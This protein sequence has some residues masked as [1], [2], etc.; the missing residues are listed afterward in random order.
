MKFD[1]RYLIALNCS[2]ALHE[3]SNIDDDDDDSSREDTAIMYTNLNGSYEAYGNRV[4]FLNPMTSSRV[5]IVPM[6]TSGWRVISVI[7]CVL[8][9]H[10]SGI[11]GVM[12]ASSNGNIFRVTGYLCGEFTG[13]R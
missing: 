5:S 11:L 9:N 6:E 12:M 1:K 7:P 4:M 13:H 3:K 2:S 10:T 8:P